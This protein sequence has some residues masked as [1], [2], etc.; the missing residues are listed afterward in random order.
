MP[1]KQSS[2]AEVG[3]Q[4]QVV[5]DLHNAIIADQ[6]VVTDDQFAAG[7]AGRNTPASLS[8]YI[9]GTGGQRLFDAAAA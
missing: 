8:R 9:D 3:L 5:N 7:L 2:D 6:L 1:N 4:R